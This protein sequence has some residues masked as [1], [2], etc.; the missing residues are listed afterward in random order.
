MGS[1]GHAVDSRPIGGGGFAGERRPTG[2]GHVADSRRPTGGTTNRRA[3]RLSPRS[4]SPAEWYVQR[5]D[6]DDDGIVHHADHHHH[7]HHHHHHDDGDGDGDDDGD[8]NVDDDDDDDGD[9]GLVAGGEVA[10]GAAGGVGGGDLSEL[11]RKLQ[12]LLGCAP[13]Q[14]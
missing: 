9:E 13:A 1:R 2:S 5:C 4:S 3:P 6:S 8:G 10:S 11:E 7:H 14:A 12:L